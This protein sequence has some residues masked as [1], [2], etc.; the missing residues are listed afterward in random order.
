M[1][2]RI[3]PLKNLIVNNKLYKVS[4]SSISTP[5]EQLIETA[6]LNTVKVVIEIKK[7]DKISLSDKDPPERPITSYDDKE[8]IY[9]PLILSNQLK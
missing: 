7:V 9:V 6:L 8:E 4:Q 5:Q 3:L 2:C 1:S